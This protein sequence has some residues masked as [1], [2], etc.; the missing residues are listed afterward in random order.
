MMWEL[1]FSVEVVEALLL[2]ATP[3]RASLPVSV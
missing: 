3:N 2:H 1:R